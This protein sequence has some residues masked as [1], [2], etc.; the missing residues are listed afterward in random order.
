M[1]DLENIISSIERLDLNLDY[2]RVKN[3]KSEIRKILVYLFER[4]YL[5]SDDFKYL[6]YISNLSTS[7][8]LKLINFN[9]SFNALKKYVKI[10]DRRANNYFKKA[11]RVVNDNINRLYKNLPFISY[12]SNYLLDII[13]IKSISRYKLIYFDKSRNRELYYALKNLSIALCN[14]HIKKMDHDLE[15]ELKFIE[16]SLITFPLSSFT[17]KFFNNAVFKNKLDQKHFLHVITLFNKYSETRFPE[18]ELFYNIQDNKEISLKIT[19]LQIRTAIYFLI[20]NRNSYARQVLNTVKKHSDSIKKNYYL[21]DIVVDFY[22]LYTK[23]KSSLENLD[24]N[25]ILISKF[26]KLSDVLY[27]F[28]DENTL[29]DIRDSLYN[30]LKKDE[31]EKKPLKPVIERHLRPFT[32]YI[33]KK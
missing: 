27:H 1:N 23:F 25:P 6:F 29:R 33:I 21:E 22:Q 14:Y 8:L 7:F 20:K 11:C 17:T 5:P 26:F 13:C 30:I 28:T 19:E 32:K 31:E 9:D 2:E 16:F 4:D 18:H 24:N 3:E 15:E 12:L 10:N